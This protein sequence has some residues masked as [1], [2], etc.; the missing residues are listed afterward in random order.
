MQITNF[1]RFSKSL[2]LI[3]NNKLNNHENNK[4]PYANSIPFYWDNIFWTRQ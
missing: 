2:A 4:T 1:K 3:T